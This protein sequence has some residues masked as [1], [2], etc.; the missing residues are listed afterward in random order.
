MRKFSLG[1][2]GLAALGL[3][4]ATSAAD[5]ETWR[6]SHKM[7]PESVE[8][9]LFQEF[10]DKIAEKT[11]GEIEVR[12]FP[13][14][15]LGKDDTVLEQLQIGT[16]DVYPEGISYLQKWV[17]EMKWTSA[18]FLFDDRDHWSRFMNTDLVQGWLQRVEDEAGIAVIGDSTKFVRGPYRVMVTN[19]PWETLDEMQ[20]IKLRMHPDELA[21]DAWRH[22]G[23]E[24]RTLGWT[25]VYESISR[26]I[27]D[28]VN[29]PVAL[30]E[31]MKFY[32]VA[33]HV[34]RHDEY[35]QGMAFM[36]NARKWNALPEETRQQVLDAY[37]EVAAHS[38]EVMA[39]TAQTDID[40]MT[41]GDVSYTE[42]DT[43]AFVER[44]K[45]FYEAR[46]EAGELPEGFLEAVQQTRQGS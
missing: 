28:A 40:K 19:K 45:S 15:Q 34:I 46:G 14:E 31:P 5:A 30:V 11:G 41:A 13:S 10:A 8:G 36:T 29:S 1:L 9:R 37:E 25:E 7:P 6:M 2:A 20:G 39:D 44:M 12:V 38:Q 35:E 26:G 3:A 21:A 24:V 18:P 4:F 17:P 32:E 42:P 23:A 33:P 16:I 27:V 43:S 22:L